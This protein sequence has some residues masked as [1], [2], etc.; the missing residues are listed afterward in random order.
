MTSRTFGRASITLPDL[1]GGYLSNVTSLESGRGTVQDFNYA[2]ADLRELDLANAH[3][4]TGRIA[5]LRASRVQLIEVRVDSV[6]FDGCDLGN[7]QWV[8]SRLSR[9]VFKNCKFM[10][11]N[12]S[13]LALDN[14]LFD[15][16]RLDYSTFEKLR[17]TGPPAFTHCVLTESTFTGC[18]LGAA[19]FDDCTLR[20][21]EFGRGTYKATDLRGNDLTAIR[22]IGNLTKVVID[23]A[24]QIELTQA[25]MAELDI[26]FGDD[27][28]DPSL[29]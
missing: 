13:G 22:G 23:R 16:C 11:G 2:D 26:T 8:G 28:D 5:N 9:V 24:Q 6:E 1:G 7:L 14:V 25:L 20:D 10:A 17:A 15:S 21:A 4:I 19:V 29:A 27:L 3:L 18:D 12:L